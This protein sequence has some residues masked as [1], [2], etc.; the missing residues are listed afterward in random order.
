MH[1]GCVLHNSLRAQRGGLLPAVEG[2][3]M[4]G[5]AELNGRPGANNYCREAEQ[6][7]ELFTQY[8]V[9]DGSVYWQDDR[10]GL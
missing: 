6:V 1:T 4:D 10:V 5:L 9:G 3:Q 8:F 2:L 7:R